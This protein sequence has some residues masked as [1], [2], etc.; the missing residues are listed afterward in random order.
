MYQ[1]RGKYVPNQVYSKYI[2]NMARVTL[3]K[4]SASCFPPCIQ[5]TKMYI[6]VA[7]HFKAYKIGGTGHNESGTN[8]GV[9]AFHH[10]ENLYFPC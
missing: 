10:A 8:W 5:C 1:Q 7:K 3:R 9:G 2:Q 6:I 4:A